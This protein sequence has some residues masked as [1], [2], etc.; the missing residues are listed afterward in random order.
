MGYGPWGCKESDMI[1]RLNTTL[2]DGPKVLLTV[3]MVV[4]VYHG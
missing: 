4:C 2:L 3:V 1:E